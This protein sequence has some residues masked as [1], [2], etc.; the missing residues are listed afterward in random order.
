[1]AA[2]TIGTKPTP[3]GVP[4]RDGQ[5]THISFAA[6]ETV[7]FWEKTVQPFGFDGGEPVDQTTMH[8]EE[9]LT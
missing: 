6:D 2:P 9:V 8:N 7:G 1:M 4:L 3:T 5:W